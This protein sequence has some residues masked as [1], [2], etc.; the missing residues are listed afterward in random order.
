MSPSDDRDYWHLTDGGWK[1]AGS[2]TPPTRDPDCLSVY[3]LTSP[4]KM[5][6]RPSWEEEWTSSDTARVRAAKARHGD[7]PKMFTGL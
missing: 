7:R 1:L 5:Y 6:S 2:D 4:N 3:L